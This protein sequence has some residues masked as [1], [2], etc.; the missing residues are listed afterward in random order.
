MVSEHRSHFGSTAATTLLVV[1]A[2]V[3]T[4]LLLKREMRPIP[5]GSA[6]LHLTSQPDWETYF[7]GGHRL[8]PANAAAVM[9]EFADFQ[10]PACRDLENTL[11]ILS[12]R[13]PK[14]FAI[15]FRQLPLTRIHPQAQRAA[16]ASECAS[17]QDRFQAMHATLFDKRD[18]LGV[19][20]WRRFASEAKVPDL[21]VFDRCMTDTALVAQLIKHDVDAATRLGAKGT[22]TGLIDGVRF[23]GTLPEPVLDSLV[24]DA[25]HRARKKR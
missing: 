16:F 3:I 5:H 18:S 12:A 4:I 23:D 6:F 22:P 14:D 7:D 13:Y 15:I 20:P 24:Q 11:R 1:C 17:S 25:I 9:V 2:V 10:C 8:G 19:T 21:D